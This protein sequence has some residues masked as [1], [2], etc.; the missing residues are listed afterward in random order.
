MTK[1]ISTE[2]IAQGKSGNRVFLTLFERQFEHEGNPRKYFMVSRDQVPQPPETKKPDA[3][4]IVAF[5]SEKEPRIVLTDEYRVAIGRREV[6]FPAG[7]I[8]GQDFVL[9]CGDLEVSSRHAAVREFKEETGMTLVP[10]DNSPP[11]LYSSAGFT[12]ESVCIV[13]GRA[14]G[15]PSRDFLD[16]HE[17][18]NSMLLTRLQ[19]LDLLDRRDVVFGKVAWPFLWA[20][21]YLPFENVIDG[22]TPCGADCS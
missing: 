1:I 16:G 6:G 14:Q 5:T 19:L 21:Q 9:G 13:F 11:N 22:T 7:L 10:F 17:D 2:P 8:D 12:D 20:F 18:I 3:V 4:V 15:E